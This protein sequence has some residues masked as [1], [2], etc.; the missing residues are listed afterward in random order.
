MSAQQRRDAERRS[1]SDVIYFFAAAGADGGASGAAAAGGV[2][3]F[4]MSRGSLQ[5]THRCSL[6]VR[7][8]TRMAVLTEPPPIE[9]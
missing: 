7:Q 1:L 8:V 4:Q 3:V 6:F 5:V 2:A 9:V